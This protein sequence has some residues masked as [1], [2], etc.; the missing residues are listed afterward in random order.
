MLTYPVNALIDSGSSGDFISSTFVQNH[1][2]P[3]QPSPHTNVVILADGTKQATSNMV[4][5]ASL[6]IANYSA[7]VD[8]MVLPLSQYDII[9]GM[10]WLERTNPRIDWTS[11]K[12]ELN[13]A[14]ET[15]HL[16]SEPKNQSRR[17][18]QRREKKKLHQLLSQNPNPTTPV[19]VAAATTTAAD[20]AVPDPV[21]PVRVQ[22]LSAMQFEKEMRRCKENVYL[23]L[24]KTTDSAPAHEEAKA[25][26]K[27]ESEEPVLDRMAEEMIQE[28]K[29][30]FPD[31][32]PH[33]LPPKRAIEHKI[34]L[35]VGSLPTSRGVYRMSTTELAELKKQLQELTDLGFIRPSE[36]PYGA[37]VLFVKKKDGVLRMCV[38]YRALNKV[39]I[40]NKYPLPHI[41]ELF[42]QTQGAQY[43]S[44]IDLRSGYH[45]VRIAD[46]DV[47]KTAFRTRYGHFEFLV[48]PFGLTNAPATFMHLMQ[49]IYRP[50]PG[51]VRDCLPGR[52]PHLQ[53]DVGRAQ[54][55]HPASVGAVTGQQ[56]VCQ[57]V[58]V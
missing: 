37:P 16:H 45:Q 18:K 3:T 11:K 29:D 56:A 58:Q 26:K 1:N 33:G 17:N 49:T 28:F 48:M 14:G 6:S 8:L 23:C 25:K 27:Y 34:E 41:S 13:V 7:A 57:E 44:K 19:P 54:A 22:F 50:V 5:A 55:T 10:P 31:Q 51:R 52:H 9:L 53:Q 46:E 4:T 40:K 12:L 42:D 30:V 39:T 20:A 24:V 2:I 21:N 47:Q 32:L 43:Y 35:E 15:L 38:D 36:S